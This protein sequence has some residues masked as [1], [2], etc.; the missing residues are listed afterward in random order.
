MMNILTKDLFLSKKNNL[1]LYNAIIK[2]LSMAG[3][4]IAGGAARQIFFDEDFGS[5]DI[6][7]F[8][9]SSE[10]RRAIRN[11]LSLLAEDIKHSAY[12]TTFHISFNN[13]LI[14]LQLVGEDWQR[15]TIKEIFELFDLHCCMFAINGNTIYYTEKAETDAINKIMNLYML[16]GDKSKAHMLKYWLYKGYT[17][18]SD[19]ERDIVY[20][21]FT[22]NLKHL[23][24]SR[25]YYDN[26]TWKGLIFDVFCK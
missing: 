1:K 3:W 15:K 14:K 23:I 24:H 12:A 7:I 6:D 19:I 10:N 20:T 18:G 4:A 25:K 8:A 22:Y 17:F 21:Q 5:T 9:L 16:D 11:N 2:N 13:R 26:D